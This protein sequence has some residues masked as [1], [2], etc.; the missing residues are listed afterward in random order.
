MDIHKPYLFGEAL[1]W[2]NEN[3]SSFFFF[4]ILIGSMQYLLVSEVA[5]DQ[6]VNMGRDSRGEK[7]R[8]A[9]SDEVS[10][11]DMSIW[12]VLLVDQS[13]GPGILL[14]PGSV[15]DGFLSCQTMRPFQ[16][17]MVFMGRGYLLTHARALEY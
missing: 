13:A 2:N 14:S 3:C 9:G 17:T 15:K 12:G 11:T 1:D 7:G 5:A 10:L 4:F 16:L 6:P 8:Y